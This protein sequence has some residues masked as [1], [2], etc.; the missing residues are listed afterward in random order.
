[1]SRLKNPIKSAW[2]QVWL[3]I[4]VKNCE[5]LSITYPD[6]KRNPEHHS[7]HLFSCAWAK[8]SKDQ[9]LLFSK[10]RVRQGVLLEMGKS[11]RETSFVTCNAHLSTVMR[12][13]SKT[14]S[15]DYFQ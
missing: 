14:Q 2:S 7:D 15:L 10:S 1:M 12:G 3:S 11:I 8:V 6:P 13:N 9:P 4:T 5:I